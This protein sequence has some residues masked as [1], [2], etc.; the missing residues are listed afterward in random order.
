MMLLVRA[1]HPRFKGSVFGEK[2]RTKDAAKCALGL[3]SSKMTDYLVEYCGAIVF[4]FVSHLL[5]IM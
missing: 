2:E 5:P 1:R 3:A 4:D